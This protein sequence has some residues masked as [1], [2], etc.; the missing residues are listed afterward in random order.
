M[1]VTD[2]ILREKVLLVVDVVSV[3]LLWIATAILENTEFQIWSLKDVEM[4]I[5]GRSC[6]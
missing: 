2:T 6:S 4:K 3:L 1:L 5:R